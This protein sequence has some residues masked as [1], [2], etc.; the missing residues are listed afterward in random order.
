LVP[1]FN[2]IATGV[3]TFVVTVYFVRQRDR[4]QKQSDDLLHNILP[5]EIAARLK[6]NASMV[7]DSFESASVLFADVVDFT[8]MS[9]GMS[10]AEL[11]ALL[12]R[13]FTTFDAFVEELGLEKIKTIG[14]EYMVASGV[15][16]P[17]RD[18]AEAVADLALS[19]EITS[20]A[21]SSTAEGSGSASGSTPVRS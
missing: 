21:R 15:P 17:R 13:I 2:L 10:A 4:F 18:H 7:A 6:A 3:V 19:C 14:D 1:T 12:N 5:D 9:A 11:V 8:P 20:R 16:V